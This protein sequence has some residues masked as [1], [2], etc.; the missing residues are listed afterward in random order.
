MTNLP[1]R[2]KVEP[3]EITYVVEA[4]KVDETPAEKRGELTRVE[5]EGIELEKPVTYQGQTVLTSPTAQKTKIAL[6][7]TSGSY[8]N[9]QNWRKPITYA[10]VWLLNWAKRII[11]KYP[12]SV[13]FRQPT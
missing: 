2:E 3:P 8:L 13:I 7:I 11:K 6:P 5:K 1:E 10:I 4:G 9:P 12:G